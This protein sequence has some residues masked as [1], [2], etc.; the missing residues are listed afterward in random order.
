[1]AT[2]IV[3]ANQKGGVGK[4]SLC[5]HTAGAFVDAGKRVLVVDLDQQGNLSSVF[6]KN[7]HTLQR[8]VADVLLNGAKTIDVIQKTSIKTLDLLPANL[9][10]SDLDARLAGDD[11]S[12]YYLVEAFKTVA[13]SYDYI[14]ID[15]PPSLSKATRMALVAA[16]GVV[17]P[18]ECQDWAVKG[19][20]QILAF[21][22]RVKQRAN[23]KLIFLGFVINKFS[24]RRR[25][26]QDY[27]R[28]LKKQYGKRVFHTEFNDV[29]VFVEASAARMPIT[30]YRPRSEMAKAFRKFSQELISHVKENIH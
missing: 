14:L 22:E 4:T 11:D 15:C 29:A 2:T 17:V 25:A 18:I 27:Y 21:V 20:S 7:I 3:F 6:T 30:M 16:N 26:E 5:L 10:L 1:M 28:A 9:S 23:P 12:Q 24:P 13:S 8:T 19:S